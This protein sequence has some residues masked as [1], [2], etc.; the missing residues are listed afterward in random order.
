MCEL[1]ASFQHRS[2]LREPKNIFRPSGYISSFLTMTDRGR[3]YLFLVYLV[4]EIVIIMIHRARQN[5]NISLV[6]KQFVFWYEN[7]YKICTKK[8]VYS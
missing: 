6:K 2:V 4:R 3:I 7:L 1:E 8:D 5:T